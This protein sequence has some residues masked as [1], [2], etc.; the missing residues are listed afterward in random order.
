MSGFQLHPKLAD[1]CFVVTDWP[2]CKVL[3]MNDSRFP[4]LILV[5]ARE[6]L[7]EIYELSATDQL[8]FLHESVTLGRLLMQ[9][10]QGLKLNVAALGNMVP[11]L[12]VHH[13]VRFADDPCWPGPVWGQGTV[14]KF[15][16]AERE[17]RLAALRDL[18][19]SVFA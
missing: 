15:T 6:G 11:Q 17:R 5:P 12:H 10:W 3:L 19:T 18:L 13:I 14:I 1:D 2:L 8:Q 7:R 9:H 4:W 16:V